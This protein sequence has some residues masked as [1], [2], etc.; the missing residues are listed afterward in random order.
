VTEALM[1][2]TLIPPSSLDENGL[3]RLV[4]QMSTLPRDSGTLNLDL[5]RVVFIDSY[6]MIGLLALGR[7]FSQRGHKLLI[8]LPLSMEVQRRLDRMN[9][10]RYL[11]EYYIMYP[12][13]RPLAA[14]AGRV[15]SSDVLLEITRIAQSDDAHKILEKV[16]ERAAA[17]LETHLRY[18]EE[19]VQGFLAALHEICKNIIQHSQNTG[20]VGIHKCFNE[21]LNINIVNIA[22]MDLGIGFKESLSPRLGSRYGG[23]WSDIAALEEAF[24]RGASG[25]QEAGRGHGLAAVKDFVKRWGAKLSIRSGTARLSLLPDRDHRSETGLLDFPGVRISLVLSEA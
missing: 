6:G 17:I 11:S 14:R 23:Q 4:V 9:F 20:L 25:H 18:K 3:E 10:F 15:Q 5:G 21:N 13:Y 8:H 22:V 19:A 2:L 16:K 12:P 7:H 1:S 24:L